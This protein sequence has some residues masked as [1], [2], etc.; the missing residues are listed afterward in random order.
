MLKIMV[1]LVPLFFLPFSL[2]EISVDTSSKIFLLLLILPLLFISE[3]LKKSKEER[4]VYL[5][6]ILDF[7]MVAFIF[8]LLFSSLMST[9]IFDS[10]FASY[11]FSHLPFYAWLAL[12]FLYILFRFSFRSKE[13]VLSV[14]RLVSMLFV[15][16]SAYVFLFLFFFQD[17]EY[18]RYVNLAIGAPYEIAM[19][20]SY[21]LF[22]V[23]LSRSISIFCIEL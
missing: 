14:F 18:E 19:I 13:S 21:L 1:L 2:F 7:S 4:S 23:L 9:T 15:L 5:F 3:I 6:S 20:L 16:L 22:V 10:F 17:T 12:A 11:R 8:C